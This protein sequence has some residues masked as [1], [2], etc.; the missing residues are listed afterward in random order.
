MLTHRKKKNRFDEDTENL[1]RDL[2]QKQV[3]ELKDFEEKWKDDDSHD[4]PEYKESKAQLEEKFRQEIEELR[5]S[6]QQQK[7]QMMNLYKS[8]QNEN[9]KKTTGSRKSKSRRPLTSQGRPQSKRSTNSTNSRIKQQNSQTPDYSIYFPLYVWISKKKKEDSANDDDNET[10]NT[11]SASSK[12]KRKVDKNSQNVSK[13][14]NKKQIDKDSNDNDEQEGAALLLAEADEYSYDESGNKKPKNK[15]AT[16]NEGEL[17]KVVNNQALSLL[18]AEE[19]K[20]NDFS[21]TSESI[22]SNNDL[23]STMGPKLLMLAER[24]SSEDEEDAVSEGGSPDT[25][26][27]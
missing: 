22:V 23:N 8:N 6:R 5:N 2:L 3:Q 27:K 4:S 1:E 18:G 19:S 20:K 9:S 21:A 15:S 7:Q 12:T 14:K 26:E 25:N 13:S 11:N 24:Q 10:D 16:S 17:E